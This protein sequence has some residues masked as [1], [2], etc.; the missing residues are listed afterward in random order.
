MISK[1]NALVHS[2]IFNNK[3]RQLKKIINDVPLTYFHIIII[4]FIIIDCCIISLFHFQQPNWIDQLGY[5]SSTIFLVIY[6]IEFILRFTALGP[7]NY[8][9]SILNSIDFLLLCLFAVIPFINAYYMTLLRSFTV[10][11]MIKVM[12][13]IYPLKNI[14]NLCYLGTY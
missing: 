3:Y 14:L 5:I 9:R 8:F 10:L 11:H 6:V 13:S 7:R 1:I 2:I 4:I 12:K